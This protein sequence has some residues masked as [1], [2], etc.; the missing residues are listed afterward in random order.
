[1][2]NPVSDSSSG[3][4]PAPGHFYIFCGCVMCSG[5]IADVNLPLTFFI[6]SI[7]WKTTHPSQPTPWLNIFLYRVWP[8]RV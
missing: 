6:Y 3:N 7:V 4:N 1:M 8:V 5:M 2:Y